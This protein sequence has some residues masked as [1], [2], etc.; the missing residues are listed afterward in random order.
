MRPGRQISNRP[1]GGGHSNSGSGE[2]KA[3]EKER[4]RSDGGL[5]IPRQMEVGSKS[6]ATSGGAKGGPGGWVGSATT[7]EI[8]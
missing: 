2:S 8:R 6:G 4:V 7:V 3:A 1:E 5:N